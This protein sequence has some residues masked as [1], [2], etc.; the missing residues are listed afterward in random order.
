MDSL[1]P[2]PIQ[3]SAHNELME[4]LLAAIIRDLLFQ[5][6]GSS[7]CP[8]RAGRAVLAQSL[9]QTPTAVQCVQC[10][11]STKQN[12]KKNVSSREAICTEEYCY[13]VNAETLSLPFLRQSATGACTYEKLRGRMAAPPPILNRCVLIQVQEISMF[14]PNNTG[15]F[16]FLVP[17]HAVP[18]RIEQNTSIL[19]HITSTQRLSEARTFSTNAI[20]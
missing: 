11:R 17:I 19:P 1:D 12:I 5:N 3:G 15:Q 10:N 8:A 18:K 4:K 20:N 2:F 16:W 9:K 7:A 13:S 14:A 6:N